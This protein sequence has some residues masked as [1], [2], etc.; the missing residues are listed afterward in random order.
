MPVKRQ[1]ISRLPSQA[2]LNFVHKVSKEIT[3]PA[4]VIAV[5]PK[6]TG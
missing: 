2:Y 3:K 6:K 4:S 1:N 5:H